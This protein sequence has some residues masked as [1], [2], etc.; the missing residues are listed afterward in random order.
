MTRKEG[1]KLSALR[2]SRGTIFCHTFL[3]VAEG[4]DVVRVGGDFGEGAGAV[5]GNEGIAEVLEDGD[6]IG[7]GSAFAKATA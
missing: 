4:V 2:F 1:A 5:G 3:I 7:G 6:V